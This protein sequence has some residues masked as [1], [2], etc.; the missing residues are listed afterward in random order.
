VTVARD[1]LAT[2]HDWPV[3]HEMNETGDYP[4][5]LWGLADQA[6]A[7]EVPDWYAGGLGCS[8]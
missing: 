5:V 2:S 1:V 8:G 6:A 3:L 4:E 7:G